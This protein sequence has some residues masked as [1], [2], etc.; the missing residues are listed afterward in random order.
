MYDLM[1]ISDDIVQFATRVSANENTE[2]AMMW[3]SMDTPMQTDG[4]DMGASVDAGT[5]FGSSA[6]PVTK[7]ANKAR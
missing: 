6:S 3:S 1:S 5:N 2:I 7:M 4:S